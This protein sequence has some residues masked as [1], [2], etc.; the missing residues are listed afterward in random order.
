VSKSNQLFLEIIDALVD[1]GYCIVP[2]ALNPELCHSLKITAKT[3]RDYKYAGIS[4]SS[5]KHLDSRRRRD[6]ISWLTED[7]ASQSHYLDFMRKL[8]EQLNH[9]LYLGINY[10][11]SHFA[12]Y[13]KGAFYEKHI[14]AFK[15]EKNRVITTVYYLNDVWDEKDGGELIM[16]NEENKYIDTIM[17]LA[18]TLVI[19]LSEKFPHE[20]LP[21]NKPRLSI[22]GWFRIDKKFNL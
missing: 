19:F 12:I 9:Q 3:Q 16:Y 4:K 5:S 11:E 17:P 10:Y 7:R 22:A 6:K 1:N 21:A 14:D 8:Q 2:N 13:E 18:N 20:V 15:G